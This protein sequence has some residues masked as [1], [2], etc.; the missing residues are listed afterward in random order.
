LSDIKG[1]FPPA[2]RLLSRGQPQV[3]PLVKLAPQ[4]PNG[5]DRPASIDFYLP[6]ATAPIASGCF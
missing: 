1:A 4:R 2:S 6:A 5:P 3:A